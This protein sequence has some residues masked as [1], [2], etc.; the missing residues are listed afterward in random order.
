MGELATMDLSGD[1]KVYWDARVPA[2]VENARQTF[3]T[4]RGKGYAAYKLAVG[5]AQGEQLLDF[6]PAAERIILV[7]AMQGG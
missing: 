7:P 6:D 1:T 5:G 3:R 4:L 2:E